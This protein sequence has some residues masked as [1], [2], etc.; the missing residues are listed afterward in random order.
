MPMTPSITVAAKRKRA[1]LR[2]ALEARLAACKLELHPQKT[3]I[4]YCKDANRRGSYP[5]QAFDFLGYTFRP[6]RVRNRAGRLFISFA[7]AVSDRAAK[8]MRQRVR[9][10]R[11]HHRTDLALDAIAQWARPVVQGWVG[12]TRGFTRPRFAGDSRTLD[13]YLVRWAQRK[14]KR[15]RGHSKRA[16]DWLKRVKARQP[17]LFPHWVPA[18]TVGR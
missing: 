6:R 2:E 4:V 11:L 1:R 16:W 8:A 3:K 12:T 9:R 14:Y 13:H 5:E 10:W 7:P 17:T 15:L 18:S